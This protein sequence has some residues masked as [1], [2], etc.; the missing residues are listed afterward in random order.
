MVLPLVK[1][2]QVEATVFGNLGSEFSS[3]MPPAVRVEA[4]ALEKASR[5]HAVSRTLVL[6][7]LVDDLVRSDIPVIVLKGPAIAIAAY[8]DCSRRIFADADLLLHRS[9]LGRARDLVL[10]RGY[11]PSFDPARESGLIAGQNA[12]EFSNSRAMVELHWTLLSRHLRFNLNVDDLWSQSQSRRCVNSEMKT[13]APE[14][15]FLYLCAHGAKHEWGLFRW[16][17]DIAQL[18][19]RLTSRQAERVLELASQAHAK[20]LLALGLRLV[21]EM[22]GEEPSPFPPEAFGAERETA[23]LVAIVRARLT[24]SGNGSSGLLPKR[25][26]DIHRY[27]EPLAFWIASRE[28]IVDRMACA[29]Q[30]FFIPAAGDDRRGQMQRVF[31]PI[32]LAANALRRLAQPS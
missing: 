16:I 18:A 30:F 1:R 27:M 8:D 21:G 17:C 11:A 9:D 4:A 7:N 15:L 5:A 24:S 29:A 23:R 31:R 26:A 3:A 22:F 6:M 25:I 2:W 20:R 13:L 32:R 14:H 19:E 28:R 12:L 10:A